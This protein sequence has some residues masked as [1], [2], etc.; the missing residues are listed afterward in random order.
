MKHLTAAIYLSL[1]ILLLSFCNFSGFYPI[2]GYKVFVF[3]IML[4][5]FC[6]LISAIK[7]YLKRH[8]ADDGRKM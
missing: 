5:G 8:Y 2:V 3:V 1:G 6:Y 4:V 7:D